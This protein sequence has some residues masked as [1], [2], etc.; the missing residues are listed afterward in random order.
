MN[1]KTTV[2]EVLLGKTTDSH[3]TDY[4]LLQKLT[5]KKSLFHL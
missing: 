5:F 1:L 4:K 2:K 3:F